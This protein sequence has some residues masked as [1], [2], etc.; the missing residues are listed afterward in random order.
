MRKI[1]V[2]AVILLLLLPAFI[3][4][5]NEKKLEFSD[6]TKSRLFLYENEKATF[7]VEYNGAGEEGVNVS[8]EKNGTT[9][10]YGITDSEGRAEIVLPNTTSSSPFTVRAVK[11]GYESDS[12]TLWILEKPKLYI[13]AQRI[14]EEGSEFE[15]R[16]VDEQARAVSD[17]RVAFGSIE[18]FT[19]SNGTVIFTA[20][21]VSISTSFYL[22]ASHENYDPA[23][24]FEMWIADNRTATVQSPLWITEGESFTVRANASTITFA[25]ESKSG[26]IAT[27]KAPEVDET[28]AYQIMAYNESGRLVGYSIIVVLNRARER[29]L[30]YSSIEAMEEEEID[31]HVISLSDLKAKQ[32]I[33]VEFKGVKRETDSDGV[34]TFSAP[35]LNEEYKQYVARV[36]DENYS[37][38]N[39]SIW[40]RKS[41]NKSL[42]IHAPSSVYEGENVTFNVTTADGIPIFAKVCIENQSKYTDR[43][44]SVTFTMPE[45]KYPTYKT[46]MASASGYLSGYKSIYVKNKEK[47]LCIDLESSS[48]NEGEQFYVQIKDSNGLNISDTTVWFNFHSHHTDSDGR[49][50]LTAPDVLLTTNYLISAEKEGYEGTSRWITVLEN[51]LGKKY[52]E[53]IAPDAVIPWSDFTV[54]AIDKSGSG[55]D[56]VTIEL[57][58]DSYRKIYTT[59]ENGESEL[60]A[61]VLGDDYFFTITAWKNSYTE[62]SKVV[63]LL[64]HNQLFSDLQVETSTTEVVER[65]DFVITVK[66]ESGN[67]IED[68]S[69]YVDG[70]LLT[71]QTDSN[72]IVNCK[73]PS[74]VVSRPC[75]IFATK[76]GYNFGYTWINVANTLEIMDTPVIDTQDSVYEGEQFS[77]KIE[78]LYGDPLPGVSVKFNSLSKITDEN[79]ETYFTAP[80]VSGD[81]FFLLTVEEK[82]FAPAFKMIKV[83][84]SSSSEILSLRVSSVPRVLEGDRFVVTVKDNYGYLVDDALIIFNNQVVGYTNNYG[85]ISLTAPEVSRDKTFEIYATKSGYGGAVFSIEVRNRGESFLSQYLPALIAIIAVIVIAVFAYFYYRQYMI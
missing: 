72:G 36:C 17:A 13:S 11:E 49:V 79:G 43:N 25:G 48:V 18:G 20:P 2:I 34:V 68:A 32:N 7:V 85:Q 61:P 59:K 33:C 26:S 38:T 56:N 55:I 46:V 53:L 19:D 5:G 75:F 22:S 40:I 77:V 51:G 73:A 45:V 74:V 4:L 16:V 35:V 9:Y 37:A 1:S 62:D 67:A 64:K 44:G 8:I 66:D 76:P 12:F 24:N 14:V 70:K 42:I 84:D 54:K 28:K 6:E 69:V 81:T 29:L 52:M 41:E 47:R 57:E 39:W 27:F 80:A 10:A 15:V 31:F 3:S 71:D 50:Y 82:G 60:R 83:I 21:D 30:L 78:D 23:D 65:D 63:M 58:Y